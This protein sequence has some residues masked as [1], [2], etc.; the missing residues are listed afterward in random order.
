MAELPKAHLCENRF[1][2]GATDGYCGEFLPDGGYG[3]VC[4]L[5]LAENTDGDLGIVEITTKF[6]AKETDT[7]APQV[8]HPHHLPLSDSCRPMCS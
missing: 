5:L 6:G 1:R 2:T 7:K 4:H 8:P 3:A